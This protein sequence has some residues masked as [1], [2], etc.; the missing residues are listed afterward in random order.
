MDPDLEYR[1]IDLDNVFPDTGGQY[2][3]KEE[4]IIPDLLKQKWQ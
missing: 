4:E 3:K 2:A 1:Y